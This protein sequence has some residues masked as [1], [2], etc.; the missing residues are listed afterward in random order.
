VEQFGKSLFWYSSGLVFTYVFI[1]VEVAAK[2]VVLLIVTKNSAK[3]IWHPI[4]HSR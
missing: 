1:E 4:T 2:L 3:G